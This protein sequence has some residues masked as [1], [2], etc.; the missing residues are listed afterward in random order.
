MTLWFQ[1]QEGRE[2]LMHKLNSKFLSC[3]SFIINV[4]LK[5]QNQEQNRKHLLLLSCHTILG[6][7]STKDL[8]I[9]Q[10]EMLCHAGNG[11]IKSVGAARPTTAPPSSA[12]KNNKKK[13]EIKSEYLQF[14][15]M[16]PTTAATTPHQ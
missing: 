7:E 8:C 4:L 1:R 3:A 16:M 11:T 14:A 15:A 2:I 5:Q 9:V 6:L 10:L 13:R 12:Y